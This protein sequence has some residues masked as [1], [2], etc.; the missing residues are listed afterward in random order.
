MKSAFPPVAISW[1]LRYGGAEEFQ[2]SGV[3][4]DALIVTNPSGAQD[5]VGISGGGPFGCS[6]VTPGVEAV[7][8]DTD[9]P[10]IVSAKGAGVLYLY[11]GGDGL[12]IGPGGGLSLLL[13][14]ATGWGFVVASPADTVN[15]PELSSAVAGS[16]PGLTAAGADTNIDLVLQGKGTG[17]PKFPG[18]LKTTAIAAGA[19]PT[20]AFSSGVAKQVEA[21]RDAHLVVPV[22]YTPTAGAA[23]TCALALSPD[24]L[25]YSTLVTVTVPLGTALDSFVDQVAVAV[26]AGWWVRL[27]VAN[28]TLG[29]GTW[30]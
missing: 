29:T 3:D 15:Y 8:L 18:G 4:N 17:A 1:P 21:T 14:T 23:A 13:E 20:L 26:P 9:I 28:A 22:T 16:A 2:P 5:G 12:Q 11:G 7:G 24:N 19:L 25:T 27:T 10:L 6:Y 30:Y